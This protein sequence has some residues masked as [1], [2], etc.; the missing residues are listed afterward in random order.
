MS[1]KN[2]ELLDKQ[3]LGVVW[4]TL[5]KNV[6]YINI[7]KEMTTHGLIKALSNIYKKSSASNEVFLIH[8]L[9]NI[10]MKEVLVLRI[11]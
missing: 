5:A 8:Q 7:I 9:V 3:A 1:Q 10:K 11:M 2:W 6:A 4:F